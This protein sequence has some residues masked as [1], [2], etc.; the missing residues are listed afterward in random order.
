MMK[1]GV[2]KETMRGE[3]RV[4]LVPADCRAL[5]EAGCHVCI[6]QGAGLNSGYVDADY[7][8]QGVELMASAELLYAAAQLVVK[9][10]QPLAHDL[11]Y[12]RKDHLLFSYLHLAADKQLVEQLCELGLTAIPFET[13]SS[14]QGGY[15]LLAPM[16]AVAG[17]LSI[18]RGARLLFGT[19]G[20]RGVLLGGVDGAERGRVVVLGAGVAGS[21]AATTAL[22]LEAEVHIF[23]L[24]EQRLAALKSQH[25]GLITHLSEPDVLKEV[26]QQ[27]DLVVGAVMLAGRRAPVVL[28]REMIEIM[29]NGSV[30][31]DI[32][33]DQGGCVEGVRVTDAEE[34]AYESQGVIHSAVPNMPG[35]VPRTASQSLSSAIVPYVQRLATGK[36]AG[37]VYLQ[38]AVAVSEGGVADPVLRQELDL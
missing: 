10:K 12:L 3:G 22:G 14:E 9:V 23:D 25:A 2:P 24:N 20:G 8:A 30:I 15:P 19:S 7:R 37:D 11:K 31:V 32:A 1:I 6:E 21:H 17:R 4:A 28:T 34:L 18:I 36:L 5:I 33:I 29:P 35:A 26:C 27:A 16:S 13:V 38:A